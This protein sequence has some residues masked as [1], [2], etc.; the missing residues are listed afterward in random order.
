MAARNVL[1]DAA[2]Q[3]NEDEKKRLGVIAGGTPASKSLPAGG[4]KK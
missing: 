4:N 1:S 2:Y 3:W